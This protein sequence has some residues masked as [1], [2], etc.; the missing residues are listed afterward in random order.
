MKEKECHWWGWGAKY[1]RNNLI[2]YKYCNKLAGGGKNWNKKQKRGPF[3][4]DTC[5]LAIQII[6]FP[7]SYYGTH[8]GC[9]SLYEKIM[10]FIRYRLA[11]KPWNGC[12]KP[13]RTTP[14]RGINLIRG[15][16]RVT[17]QWSPCLVPDLRG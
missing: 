13:D 9:Y 12:W 1:H 4:H 16:M 6:N 15:H 17:S 3:G 14:N 11:V 7:W 5:G 10:K 8:A 2:S